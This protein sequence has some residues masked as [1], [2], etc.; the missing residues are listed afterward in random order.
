MRTLLTTQNQDWYR[1]MIMKEAYTR[2]AWNINYGK[3]YPIK[4]ASRRSK[5]LVLF[6]PPTTNKITLPP[7]VQ[8]IKKKVE[9]KEPQRTLT[10][11]PLMRPVS[12][13]SREA[14]YHGLTTEGKGRGQ[15]LQ[16]RFQK[17]PEERFDYPI[18]SSWEY[19]WRLGDYEQS[20][21]SPAN[22]RSGVVRSNFYARN[23]VFYIPSAT[24][25]LG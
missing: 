12:P 8:T 21:R 9:P 19:G 18:L 2:L 1:E 7:V 24:D 23:G 6:N 17:R 22:G 3:D 16:K 14:L 11:T 13:Q 25:R 15:Y 4:F 20:Y 10:E 5:P